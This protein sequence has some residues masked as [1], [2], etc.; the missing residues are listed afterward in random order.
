M[1]SD[2]GPKFKSREFGIFTKQWDINHIT[3]GPN[4][5]QANAWLKETCN[6]KTFKSHEEHLHGIL[7]TTHN[8]T[9]TWFLSP[10]KQFFLTLPA[11]NTKIQIK[12]HTHTHELHILS[13]NECVRIR[14]NNWLR[15]G[16]GNLKKKKKLDHP[17]FYLVLTEERN[18]NKTQQASF[19]RDKGTANKH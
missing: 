19:I 5:T 16:Q 14:F 7:N 13:P 3:A 9:K 17:R 8:T 11:I 1:V 12:T 2:N 4:Y 18:K 6:Q 15:K 10:A